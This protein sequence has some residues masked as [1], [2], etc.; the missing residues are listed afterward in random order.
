MSDI[1]D[2]KLAEQGKLKIEWAARNMPVLGNG[3]GAFQE[4]KA[5]ERD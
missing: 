2:N 1:K 5:A 3:E 4:N